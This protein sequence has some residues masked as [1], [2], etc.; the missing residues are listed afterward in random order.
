[1]HNVYYYYY[2]FVLSIF[3]LLPESPDLCRWRNKH[4]ENWNPQ[5]VLD[6]LFYT[7]EKCDLD[8]GKLIIINVVH[9]QKILLIY[10]EKC[11]KCIKVS[12]I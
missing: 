1:V 10:P 3:D 4:P 11:Y 6:W 7:A 2:Y 12:N 9:S 5:D 8:C